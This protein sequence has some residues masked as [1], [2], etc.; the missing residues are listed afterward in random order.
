MVRT[1]SNL[2]SLNGIE[3]LAAWSAAIFGS[4]SLCALAI[5]GILDLLKHIAPHIG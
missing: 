2:P 4:H 1:D 5:V 3:L